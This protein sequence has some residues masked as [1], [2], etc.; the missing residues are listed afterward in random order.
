M[1]RP[2]RMT[3]R[4]LLLPGVS[5]AGGQPMQPATAM[6]LDAGCQGDQA[7]ACWP[8][9]PDRGQDRLHCGRDTAAMDQRR[10]PHRAAQAAQQGVMIVRCA[11][12]LEP[13]VRSQTTARQSDG[14]AVARER[15]DHAGLIAQPEQSGRRAAIRAVQVTVGDT[16]NSQRTL[17]AGNRAVETAAKVRD[18]AGQIIEQPTPACSDPAKPRGRCQ[19]AQHRPVVLHHLQAGVTVRQQHKLDAAAQLF[20]LGTRQRPIH[21]EAERFAAAARPQRA[22]K[23]ML[24]CGK[25]HR[26]CGDRSRAGHVRGKPV[27]GRLQSPHILAAQH[28]GATGRRVP[29]QRLVERAAGQSHGRER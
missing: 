6:P 29:Q 13:S 21:L 17:V 18:L 14:N 27:G 4:G 16:R 26:G 22:A 3:W 23:V 11:A 9:V 10:D 15:G 7:H 28:L 19:H 2:V 5:A 25:E 24:A 20:L 8:N 12:A 1:T